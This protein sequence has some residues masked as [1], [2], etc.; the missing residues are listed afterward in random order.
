MVTLLVHTVYHRYDGVYH[1]RRPIFHGRCLHGVNNV[2]AKK[3]GVG[4]VSPTAFRRR[5]VPHWHPLGCGAI[6]LGKPSQG[7]AIYNVVYGVSFLCCPVDPGLHCLQVMP[8]D[9]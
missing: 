7:C 4:S 6:E 8:D 5:I 1:T 2:G 9:K 3:V